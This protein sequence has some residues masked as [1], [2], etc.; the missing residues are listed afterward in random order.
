MNREDAIERTLEGMRRFAKL[1]E[2]SLQ[3]DRERLREQIIE[4]LGIEDA[5]ALVPDWLGVQQATAAAKRKPR[6][7]VFDDRVRMILHR[8][9]ADQGPITD[10]AEKVKLIASR[11]YDLDGGN[12]E[13]IRRQVRRSLKA[14]GL[15]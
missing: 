15:R 8:I 2:A 10:S 6:E 12:V 3:R 13:S 7:R 5:L 1:H 4:K 14:Q 9:E 11:L